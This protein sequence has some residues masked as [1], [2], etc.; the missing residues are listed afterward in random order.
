MPAQVADGL[1][2]LHTEANQVH[3]ALCPHTVF[4]TAMGAWKLGGLSLACP[5]FITAE[6]AGVV[7]VSYR[8]PSME[9]FLRWQ[10]VIPCRWLHC[11]HQR[12]IAC[13]AGSCLVSPA[14]HRRQS[15]TYSEAQSR[16][17]SPEACHALA[18]DVEEACLLTG[19]L[20]AASCEEHVVTQICSSCLDVRLHCLCCLCPGFRLQYIL[21]VHAASAWLCGA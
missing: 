10:Q 21:C 14:F 7:P 16:D 1:H 13:E 19:V 4:I 17:Y 2:F 5:S 20:Q 8:D 12:S 9:R 3:R 18:A 11:T 15:A 6:T